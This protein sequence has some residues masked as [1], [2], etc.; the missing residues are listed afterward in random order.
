[1]IFHEAGDEA[2]V[3]LTVGFKH[4]LLTWALGVPP[5]SAAA[6]AIISNIIGTIHAAFL[7]DLAQFVAL[8]MLLIFAVHWIFTAGALISAVSLTA[9]RVTSTKKWIAWVGV[10]V[11]TCSSLY[12]RSAS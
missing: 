1:M 11:S 2:H 3:D 7:E 5:I 12:I 8:P 10:L 9:R 4:V 6:L